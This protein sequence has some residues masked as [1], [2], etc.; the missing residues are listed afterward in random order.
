MV[1]TASAAR[2]TSSVHGFGYS[3]VMSIPTSAIAS[4]AAGLISRPGSDPPD[5][6]TARPAARSLNQPT[7]IWDRPALWTQRKRAAGVFIGVSSLGGCRRFVR[8]DDV[9]G[10][11]VGMQE[12]DQHD[13]AE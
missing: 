2:S 3:P 4:I 11:Y 7:A 8:N 1:M 13:R 9:G 12:L 6:A 5:H 10:G